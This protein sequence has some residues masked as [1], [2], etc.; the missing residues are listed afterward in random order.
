M[1]DKA[2]FV[3]K[4]LINYEFQGFLA[5]LVQ[6][7]ALQV[8]IMLPATIIP[9]PNPPNCADVNFEVSG[10]DGF[11]VLSSSGNFSMHSSILC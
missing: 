8:R 9:T 2:G 10:G 7:L 1:I 6:M 3:L 11:C 5:L 4:A